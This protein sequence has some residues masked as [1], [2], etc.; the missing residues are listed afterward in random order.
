MA[1][2]LRMTRANQVTLFATGAIFGSVLAFALQRLAG[3]SEDPDLAHYREVRQFVEENFVRPVDTEELLDNALNGMLTSL[4]DYSRYYSAEEAAQLNRDTAGRYTGIGVVLKRPIEEGRILFV[5]PGSPAERAGVQVG[6]LIVSVDGAPVR[7]DFRP[8]LLRRNLSDAEREP[9]MLSVVRLDGQEQLLEI[10]HASLVDPTVRHSR[11]LDP[12][13]GIGYLAITAFSHETPP[14]FLAAFQELRGRGMQA[15]VIDLRANFGGVLSAAVD[16]ARRF[17]SEGTI[18]S[19]EGTG[20]PE[21][22]TARPEMAALEGFPLVLLVDE[23]SASASEVL[24]AA[25]QEH[26]AA[27]LVGA[28]TFGKGMVQTIHRFPES[29][30]IAK[31]TTSYYYTPAHRNLEHSLDPDRDYGI[32]PDL[33]VRL[34]RSMQRAIYRHLSEYSPPF[35]SLPALEAWQ[36]NEEEALLP[37]HPEDA[38]LRAAIDLFSDQRSAQ[39]EQEG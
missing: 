21:I 11:I 9:L 36:E 31:I 4:D 18:V 10:E 25:L 39:L 3:S 37:E 30:S 33:E 28:P 29:G 14:E 13:L 19:T 32:L 7:G 20:P 26:R 38:Q 8:E 27:V 17:V 12:E 35:A 16:I 5:L 34:D 2:P 15:L 23:N 6:D 22:H 1:L 24:A